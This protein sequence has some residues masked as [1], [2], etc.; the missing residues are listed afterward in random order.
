MR[1]SALGHDVPFAEKLRTLFGRSLS[2]LKRREIFGFHAAVFAGSS[3]LGVLSF[4]P[5]AIVVAPIIFAFGYAIA[6]ISAAPVLY[7]LM[8]NGITSAW[9]FAITI[10][11][12]GIL[13]VMIW[14]APEAFQNWNGDNFVAPLVPALLLCIPVSIAY[15][16]S[17]FVY[18]WVVIA[19]ERA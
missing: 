18:W 8:R 17:G 1:N 11:A 9:A 2:F 6:L 15:G 16:L 13:A 12:A 4:G 7:L 5:F 3:I 19:R 10:A 14:A